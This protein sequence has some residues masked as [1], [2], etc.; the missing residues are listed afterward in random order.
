[1]TILCDWKLLNLKF[2]ASF[3]KLGRQGELFGCLKRAYRDV[4]GL[5]RSSKEV[6]RQSEPQ[7]HHLRNTRA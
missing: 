4:Q 2:S 5:D 7:R 6:T 3:A 1:M